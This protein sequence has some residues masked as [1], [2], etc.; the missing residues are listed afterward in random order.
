MFGKYILYIIGIISIIWIGYVGMDIIDKENQFSPTT[1]FG[2]KD[3]EILIINRLSENPFQKT[4]FET[5][6]ENKKILSKALK[7]D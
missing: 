2:E 6:P 5:T 3:G 4:G 7:S 1:L